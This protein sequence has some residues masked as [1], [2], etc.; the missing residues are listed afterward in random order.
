MQTWLEIISNR[1]MKCGGW[2]KLTASASIWF[3]S[4]KQIKWKK[5]IV[6]VTFFFVLFLK[7]ENKNPRIIQPVD[8]CDI[9]VISEPGVNSCRDPGTPAY[10]VPVLAE[11]FQVNLNTF[12]LYL[13]AQKYIFNLNFRSVVNAAENNPAPMSY[14]RIFSQSLCI[15]DLSDE[16]LIHFC[17]GKRSGAYSDGLMRCVN[18]TFNLTRSEVASG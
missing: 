6:S 3:L 16:T 9:C 12:F 17:C 1:R 11:G 13:V 18:S 2:L 10:G 14:L 4:E 15:N 8:I 5:K 7:R